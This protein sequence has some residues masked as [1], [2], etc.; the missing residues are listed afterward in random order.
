MRWG[1][2]GVRLSQQCFEVLD[3]LRLAHVIAVGDDLVKV[4]LG[5]GAYSQGNDDVATIA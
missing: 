5:A 2:C 4:G 1:S 3:L